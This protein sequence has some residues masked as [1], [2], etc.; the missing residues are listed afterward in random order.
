MTDEPKD[1]TVQT[2]CMSCGDGKSTKVVRRF[3][4]YN[5]LATKIE[6]EIIRITIPGH[7]LKDNTVEELIKDRKCRKET[8]NRKELVIITE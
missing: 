8:C 2:V 7:L 6:V 5:I 4:L 1:V 3:N